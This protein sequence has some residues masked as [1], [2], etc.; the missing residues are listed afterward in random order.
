MLCSARFVE[1]H[2]AVP[3]G[4]GG[5]IRFILGNESVELLPVDHWSTEAL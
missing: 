5:I 2:P 1:L 4:G 3:G